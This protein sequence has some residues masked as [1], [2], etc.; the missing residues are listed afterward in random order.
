MVIG[1]DSA[2]KGTQLSLIEESCIINES[3][4]QLRSRYDQSISS[5]YVAVSRLKVHKQLERTLI[6]SK[7]KG[8]LFAIIC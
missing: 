4:L 2:N 6:K 7:R 5:K 3:E 8:R 1:D